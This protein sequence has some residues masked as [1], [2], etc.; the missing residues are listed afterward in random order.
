MRAAYLPAQ[1]TKLTPAEALKAI[2]GA[3]ETL[4]GVSP[5]HGTQSLLLAQSALESGRWLFCYL[6]NLGNEK[7]GL[8]YDGFF[9]CYRCNEQLPD[10]WHW[11]VPEGELVGQFGTPLKGSPIPVPDGHPQTRFRAF[12]GPEQGAL[13]WLQLL[14]RRFPTAYAIAKAG[15]TAEGFVQAL[16]RDRY[17]TANEAPYARAVS[18]LAREY[19]ALVKEPDRDTEAPPSPDDEQMLCEAMACVA[20]DPERSFPAELR[21]LAVQMAEQSWERLEEARRA[22]RDRNMASE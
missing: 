10:G 9:Q 6:Y 20:E 11:Y 16:K 15:G 22:E 18:S 3:W 17:F 12:A 1:L 19:A 4:E 21:V 14:K 7:A 8:T 13:A 5:S 2:R